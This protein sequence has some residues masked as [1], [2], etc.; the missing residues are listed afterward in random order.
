MIA[1]ENDCMSDLPSTELT[2]DTLASPDKTLMRFGKRDGH[3]ADYGQLRTW[4]GAR[5]APREIFP[6]ARRL[7]R[8][9]PAGRHGLAPITARRRGVAVRIGRFT[10]SHKGTQRQPQRKRGYY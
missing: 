9:A 6:P 7:A 2:L 3:V 10:Q 8:P 1:G 4:S 5:Y